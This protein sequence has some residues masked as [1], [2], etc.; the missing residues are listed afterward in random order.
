[1]SLLD[2]L[3]G[4]FVEPV[5]CVIKVD[6][7]EISDLYAYL[8]EVTVNMSRSQF[9]EAILKFESPA[10]EYGERV[11]ADRLELRPWSDITIDAVFGSRTDNLFCGVIFSVSPSFPANSGQASFTM[12]CRDNA[13]RLSRTQRLQEWG[14]P[15]QPQTDEGIVGE[16]LGHH[17]L[18]PHREN[19]TGM[20]GLVLRTRET[21]I[22]LLQGRAAD[23]G[24]DLIFFQDQLYFGPPRVGAACQPTILVYAG[25]KSNCY[26]FDITNSGENFESVGFADRDDDGN[27][28]ADEVV[29]PDL[30]V[31]GTQAPRSPGN[32]L[33]D[34]QVYM[35][36]C[37]SPNP[38]VQRRRAQGRVNQESF[39]VKATGEL[40]GSVY[41]SVLVAGQ[42]VAVDGVGELYSGRY[43]VDTVTHTINSQGYR[44]RFELL[45]NGIGF[46]PCDTPLGRAIGGSL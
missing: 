22:S 45:R 19:N 5:E 9:T 15:D 14:E 13:A 4:D 39:S 36:D 32:G 30:P 29:T 46:Q 25:K 44:Q 12:T 26:S 23:N 40:D 21:D 2:A 24:F 42:P 11:V 7:Q 16:I 38:E 8:T 41:G 37:S 27:P 10:D 18:A 43:L 3:L 6:R 34:H 28:Q 31:M 1:M 20:T 35:A 17:N 33:D